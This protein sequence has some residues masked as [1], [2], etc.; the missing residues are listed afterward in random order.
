MPSRTPF[1]AVALAK[2][3]ATDHAKMPKGMIAYATSSSDTT[4]IT[5]E[6][7][8]TGMSVTV[9][10]PANRIVTIEGYYG[11]VSSLTASD[12]ASFRIK[13]STTQLAES[14]ID[15][16]TVVSGS[17]GGAT[18]YVST[19][20]FTP[21]AG[22]HTYKLTGVLAQGTGTIQF[23]A[24]ATVLAWIRVVDHGPAF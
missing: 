15:V 13:E 16:G 9:D 18:A 12:V 17:N 4:G 10:V 1:T 5:T 8:L 21:S 11:R 6:T 20:P 19:A 14:R 7:D 2:Y 3:N 24:S 23:R 22:S